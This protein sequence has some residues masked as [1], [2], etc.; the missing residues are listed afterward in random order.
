MS[1]Q[2]FRS[3]ILVV[4][5]WVW[6]LFAVANLIDL[7]VQGHD[8]ASLEAAF[9]LLFVTGAAYVTALRPRII[10]DADGLTIMNPLRDHRVG[11]PAVAGV[12]TTDLIRVRCEWPEGP[13][14]GAGRKSI[15]AWVAGASR[16]RQMVAEMRTQR[17][18]RSRLL[19]GSYAAATGTAGREP[20]SAAK[21]VSALSQRAEEERQAAPD[22][23]AA[24]P[25]SRWRWQALAA[26]LIPAL[27]LVI[28]VVL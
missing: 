22:A 6:V 11:W 16:R 12:D 8:H 21:I 3:P 18:T 15:H 26:V 13:D 2:V 24:R 14:G 7:A 19:A 23:V 1:K 10:A 20:E 17:R 5:W 28:V 25:V 27:A 4:I 9:V